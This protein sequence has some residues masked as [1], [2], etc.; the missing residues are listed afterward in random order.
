MSASLRSP[1]P[2]VY[3]LDRQAKV[4][5]LDSHIGHVFAQVLRSNFFNPARPQILKLL[6]SGSLGGRRLVVGKC[7]ETQ[8]A[9]P[10]CI[11]TIISRSRT[12]IMDGVGLLRTIHNL[13]RL[14]FFAPVEFIHKSGSSH[15]SIMVLGAPSAEAFPRPSMS[16]CTAAPPGSSS[17]RGPSAGCNFWPPAPLPQ[18]RLA[19]YPCMIFSTLKMQLTLASTISVYS[20]EEIADYQSFQ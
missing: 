15:F 11:A 14:A 9:W 3:V 7:D 19:S 8:G 13:L 2:P 16:I 12:S 10:L 17:S 4:D 20:H 6:V 18:T 5:R 1:T